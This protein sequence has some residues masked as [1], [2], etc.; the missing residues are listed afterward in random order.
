MWKQCAAAAGA[1]TVGTVHGLAEL[2]QG[3]G[4]GLDNATGGSN[5]PQIYGYSCTERTNKRISHQNRGVFDVKRSA[6]RK[7]NAAKRGVTA[8][9]NRY[10]MYWRTVNHNTGHTE[11]SK[12]WDA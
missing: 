11:Q 4:Q 2:T 12:M 6:N 10:R 9:L 7:R 1:V 5:K 3:Q 8:W